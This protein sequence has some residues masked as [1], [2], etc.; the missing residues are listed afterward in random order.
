MEGLKLPKADLIY[1]SFSL[2]FCSPP[3]F[4]ALWSTIRDSIKPGG[5]FAGQLFGDQDEWRGVRP[6]SFHSPRQVR[7]LAQGFK[8]E[9]IRESFEDGMSYAG[10]KRWHVFDLILGKPPL[11]MH[12]LSRA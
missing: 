10:P 8:V 11:A 3:R 5:H 2:P 1:A 6:L 12:S 4:S 9:L 7:R